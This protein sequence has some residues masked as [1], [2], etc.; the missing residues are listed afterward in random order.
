MRRTVRSRVVPQR[1]VLGPILFVLYIID[2]ISGSKATDCRRIPSL[3]LFKSM[4]NVRLLQSTSLS[5]DLRLR[6][7]LC[8]LGEVEQAD[9]KPG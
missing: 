8:G 6:R 5:E 7:R 9:T 4:A 3:M 1:S 2:L